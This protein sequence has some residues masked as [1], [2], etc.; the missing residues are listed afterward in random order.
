MKENKNKINKQ[1]IN[2]S[3]RWFNPNDSAKYTYK[4]IKESFERSIDK[5][6]INN[7]SA[8]QLK[9]VS[10]ILNKIDY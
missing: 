9:Q 5:Q 3:M 6:A 8:K 7:L 10:E 4:D 2:N 1:A